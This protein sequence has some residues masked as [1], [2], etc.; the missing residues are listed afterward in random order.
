M[1]IGHGIDVHRYAESYQAD[2]PLKLAGVQLPEEY[3]LVAHSDGDVILHAVCDGIL[4]A[5]AAGDIGQHFPDTDEEYADADSSQFLEQVLQIADKKQMRII[6][7][8]VTVIA[9]V[10]RLAEY[11]QEMAANLCALLSLD[12][13]RV[14]LK[15]TTTER[16]GYIGRE[17]GIACHA[18]ILME[19]HAK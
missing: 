18:V 2:K 13:D 12:S 16:L 11:R 10:P 15:A 1:R 7:L 19:A 4:G 6:S 8:D 5:C 17:E 3:S 14:N 9:Q